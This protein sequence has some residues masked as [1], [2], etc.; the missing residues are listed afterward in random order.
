MYPGN[1]YNP[2]SF[3]RSLSPLQGY[4]GISNSSRAS[5]LFGKSLLKGVSWDGFLTSAGKTLNVINQAIPIF[6]QVKP[7]F[8]NARTMFRVLGAVRGS[9]NVSN[10]MSTPSST[11]TVNLTEKSTF[12]PSNSKNSSNKNFSSGDGNPTFFL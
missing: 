6:Y 1:F 10:S 9:D 11:P 12:Q 3:S 5:G 7:I 8:H 4:S 2:Y